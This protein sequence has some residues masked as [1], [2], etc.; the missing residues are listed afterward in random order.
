MLLLLAHSMLGDIFFKLEHLNP[1]VKT[2]SQEILTPTEDPIQ[3]AI[4]DDE[5]LPIRK[6]TDKNNIFILKPQ[7]KYSITALLVARNTNFFLRDILRTDFD[8]VC[9]MDYG[10]VWGEIATKKYVQNHLKFKSNKTLGNAR[11]LEY[12]AKNFNTLPH[13]WSYINTHVSHTHLIPANKNIT[14]ALLKAKKYDVIKLEGYLVDI[15][16]ENGDTVALTSLS[17]YDKNSTSRGYGAC[18]D[19]YVTSVQIG[20]KIYK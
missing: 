16:K 5:N 8:E 14:K 20:N 6:R 9:V 4:P 2:I 19:M 17:R 3:E 18:E 10:L 12:R 7:A 13:N 11:Q 1:K 15:Y